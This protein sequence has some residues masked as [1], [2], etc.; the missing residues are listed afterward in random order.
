MKSL[1][2]TKCWNQVTAAQVTMSKTYV[3]RQGL[4]TKKSLDRHF[5]FY[6]DF[7]KLHVMGMWAAKCI[8]Q[9]SKENQ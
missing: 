5:A 1:K 2:I 9:L 8:K 7:L 3:P 4:R 6:F